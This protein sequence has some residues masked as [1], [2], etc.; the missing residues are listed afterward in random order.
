MEPLT[1]YLLSALFIAI[2]LDHYDPCRNL[3]KLWNDCNVFRDDG[4]SYGDCVSQ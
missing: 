2:G 3:L 1:V 4:M